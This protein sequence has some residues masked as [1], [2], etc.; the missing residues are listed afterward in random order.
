MSACESTASAVDDSSPTEAAAAAAVAAGA[1]SDLVN[2]VASGLSKHAS[3][4]NGNAALHVEPMDCA[5]SPSSPKPMPST[6]A[7]GTAASAV[8]P[9]VDPMQVDV[10]EAGKTGSTADG[11]ADTADPLSA[12]TSDSTLTNSSNV[13]RGVVGCGR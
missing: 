7:A 13:R 11:A 6:G 12:Q 9:E 2:D 5:S 4:V 3:A 1:S 8:P 10:M